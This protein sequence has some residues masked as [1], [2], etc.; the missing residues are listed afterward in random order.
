MQHKQATR[1]HCDSIVLPTDARFAEESRSLR[2]KR[3]RQIEWMRRRGINIQLREIERPAVTQKPP[4]PG[5][6]IDFPIKS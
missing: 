6:V 1:D 2:E 4:L 3:S 5:T